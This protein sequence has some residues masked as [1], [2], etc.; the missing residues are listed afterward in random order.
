VPFPP[1]EDHPVR[2]HR[3]GWSTGEAAFTG[4]S[5]RVVHQ[6]DGRN[7]EGRISHLSP[8]AGSGTKVN[9]PDHSNSDPV[10]S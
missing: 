6:V 9:K 10:G 3:D 4:A 8:V 5:D 1:A 2:V 7:G